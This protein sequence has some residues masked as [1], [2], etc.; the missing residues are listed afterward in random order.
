M[1]N[2][3]LCANVGGRQLSANSKAVEDLSAGLSTL[4][5]PSTVTPERLQEL[6]ASFGSWTVNVSAPGRSARNHLSIAEYLEM[7]SREEIS[8]GF[9]DVLASISRTPK[10]IA[11][12][13]ALRHFDI[14][15]FCEFRVALS[16]LSL[17]KVERVGVVPP[18]SLYD[19]MK[20]DVLIFKEGEESAKLLQV[21]A[22]EGHA[23]RLSRVIPTIKGAW[24]LKFS[25]MAKQL[26]GVFND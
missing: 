24:K 20:A 13:E 7:L 10:E 8:P 26:R 22:T 21:K 23:N 12:Q 1:S 25:E 5:F 17:P 15:R 4:Y 2:V 19:Q 18:N 9:K 16:A 6:A 11:Q 14:S 3:Y